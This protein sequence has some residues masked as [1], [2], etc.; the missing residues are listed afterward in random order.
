MCLLLQCQTGSYV[1][2]NLRLKFIFR[3]IDYTI[4]NIRFPQIIL[5]ILMYF[6]REHQVKVHIVKRSSDFGQRLQS[7]SEYN[8]RME[9]EACFKK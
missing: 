4:N 5:I 6:T 7:A 2:S 1:V 3:N 9:G 8:A